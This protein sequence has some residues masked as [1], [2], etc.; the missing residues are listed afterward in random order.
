M[1]GSM[2]MS[3][4]RTLHQ[5]ITKTHVIKRD[6]K[7][8]LPP[9]SLLNPR[10]RDQR[11]AAAGTP[12]GSITRTKADNTARGRREKRERGLRFVKRADTMR[13]TRTGPSSDHHMAWGRGMA[14]LSV[15]VKVISSAQS[16]IRRITLSRSR[17]VTSRG[18]TSRRMWI[19][20]S[21]WGASMVKGRSMVRG[22]INTRELRMR[23]CI[24]RVGSRRRESLRRVSRDRTSTRSTK[25]TA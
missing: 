14:T 13:M 22:V 12:K 6:K 3:K 18:V 21:T 2:I 9:L 24:R 8:H 17:K 7:S 20:R 5:N 15:V 16:R 25:I 10:V 4:D 23:G 11:E 19:G 1:T